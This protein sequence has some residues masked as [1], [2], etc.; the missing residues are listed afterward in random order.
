MIDIDH[1][2]QYNDVRG[3]QAGDGC[4]RSVAQVLST[5]LR[6]RDLVCRY[7][8]EEFAIIAP[9]LTASAARHVAEQVRRNVVRLCLSH[10]LGG[11]V[12]VSLGV[13]TAD[14]DTPGDA[15]ALV[16]AADAALYRAK[17][18]GRNRVE[19]AARQPSGPGQADRD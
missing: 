6:E 11:T 12:T 4:L 19:I 17:R 13:A 3:H 10:P 15:K 8:G 7:G 18:A 5:G 1:F 14:P 16:A 2:K 9:R